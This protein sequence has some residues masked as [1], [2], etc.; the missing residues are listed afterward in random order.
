M[1]SGPFSHP[2]PDAVAG[3]GGGGGRVLSTGSLMWL[4]PWSTRYI[5]SVKGSLYAVNQPC[6]CLV[7]AWLL[8]FVCLSSQG[9]AFSMKVSRVPGL[10]PET[11]C[12]GQEVEAQRQFLER[13]DKSQGTGRL[14]LCLWLRGPG[15]PRSTC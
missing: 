9:Q 14:P 3:G 13:A 10:P 8:R 7:A 2:D 15:T 6:I 5:Q 12:F 11:P 1:S 4:S